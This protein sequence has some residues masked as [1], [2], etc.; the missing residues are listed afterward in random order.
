MDGVADTRMHGCLHAASRT[1]QC[2]GPVCSLHGVVGAS[3]HGV[4]LHGA[5]LQGV[6]PLIA[7]RL[8]LAC[9]FQLNAQAVRA[10]LITLAALI[11]RTL[12]HGRRAVRCWAPLVLGYL[13]RSSGRDYYIP[14]HIY[15]SARCRSS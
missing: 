12:V 4:G 9:A 2:L 1:F 14:H 10:D 6:N 13:N 5:H 15:S 11:T 8:L 3:L 7:G